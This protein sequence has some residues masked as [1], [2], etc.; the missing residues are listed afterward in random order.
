VPF[1]LGATVSIGTIFEVSDEIQLTIITDGG[2][3]TWEEKELLLSVV[4]YVDVK[5]AA[6]RQ[7]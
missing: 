5:K 7:K 2:H 4:K 3:V 1:L 6:S